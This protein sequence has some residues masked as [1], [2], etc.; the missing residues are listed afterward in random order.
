MKIST[1]NQNSQ[2]HQANQLDEL[3]TEV[4]P[5]CLIIRK[6]HPQYGVIK[7]KWST[8]GD[9]HFREYLGLTS[10]GSEPFQASCSMK[11]EKGTEILKF[12]LPPPCHDKK[13]FMKLLADIER[14]VKKET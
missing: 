1:P 8:W 7:E 6:S 9:L 2:S 4:T 3:S 14:Q 10:S 11:I 5:G 13:A 12:I